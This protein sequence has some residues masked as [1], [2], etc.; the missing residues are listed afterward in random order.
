MARTCGKHTCGS[1][2]RAALTH[3]WHEHHTHT[4]IGRTFNTKV[5]ARQ[6]LGIRFRC[7]RQRQHGGS[8]AVFYVLWVSH[9]KFQIPAPA[10]KAKTLLFVQ[11]CSTGREAAAASLSWSEREEKRDRRSGSL[12]SIKRGACLGIPKRCRCC[13]S[14]EARCDMF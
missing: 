5:Q 1:L 4:S 14:S 12:V 8:V 3:T 13:C 2:E 7:G 9:R 6:Q 11:Q 10:K